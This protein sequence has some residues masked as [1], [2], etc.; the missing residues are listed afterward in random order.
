MIHLLPKIPETFMSS[1]N[2]WFHRPPINRDTG[3]KIQPNFFRN[4]SLDFVELQDDNFFLYLKF[5][6]R[7]GGYAVPQDPTGTAFQCTKQRAPHCPNVCSA[8]WKRS[9]DGRQFFR[10][11]GIGLWNRRRDTLFLELSKSQMYAQGN[12]CSRSK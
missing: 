7:W 2:T 9:S 11:F 5:F 10:Q 12:R 8:G 3:E 4:S 1:Q 6:K